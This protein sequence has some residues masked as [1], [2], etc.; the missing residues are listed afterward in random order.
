MRH[1]EK[2]SRQRKPGRTTSGLEAGISGPWNAPR[3]SHY[4][5]GWPA[6]APIELRAGTTPSNRFQ[7]LT[8][9]PTV[10]RLLSS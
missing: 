3:W 8:V 4:L 10:N 2:P 7:K 1:V 5:L 6:T 9:T